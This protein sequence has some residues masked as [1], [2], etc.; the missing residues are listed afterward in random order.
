MDMKEAMRFW[1]EWYSQNAEVWDLRF[2]LRRTAL[3]QQLVRR[4]QMAPGSRV[5]DVGTGTGDAAMQ[6][7]QAV[8]PDGSVVGIDNA[9]GMLGVARTKVERL[10]AGTIEFQLMDLSRLEFPDESFDH[11]ISSFAIYSSFPPGAGLRE[12]YRV[13]RHGGKLTF[14]MF[15]K[16]LG[17][18]SLINQIYGT[19]F[20]RYQPG[21]PSELLQRAREAS[22]LT[23]LGIMRYG[24]LSEPSDPSAVLGFMRSVGFRD[25]EAAI[26]HH[27]AVFSTI[28]EFVEDRSLLFFPIVYAEMTSE[29]REAFMEECRTSMQPLSSDGGL[30]V[31]VEVMFYRGT[32]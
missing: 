7:L 30:V 19:I 12:A 10:A 6:A 27:R 9:E 24:P 25:V 14:S 26:I 8:G 16:H 23:Y 22:A 2:A 17:A 29:A 18:S 21:K 31:E 28:D 5:L 4:A 11:V 32:K 1:T 3:Y 13:L 15:G 20:E